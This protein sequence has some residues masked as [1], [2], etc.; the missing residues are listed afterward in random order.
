MKILYSRFHSFPFK[1]RDLL[2]AFLFF[3]FFLISPRVSPPFPPSMHIIIILIPQLYSNSL[4][5]FIPI[6]FLLLFSSGDDNRITHHKGDQEILMNS[7]EKM[8]KIT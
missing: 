6:L 5:C 8:K 4:P 3:L 2:Y 1:Y 7:I